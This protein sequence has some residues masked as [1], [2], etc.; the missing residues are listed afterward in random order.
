MG[1]IM[2]KKSTLVTAPPFP[3]EQA[4]RTLGANLRTARLR[5]KLSLGAVA[6]K[7]G[8]GRKI[9]ADAERGKLSTGI[10]VYVAL[11]WIYGLLDQFEEVAEPTR[12]REGQ[13]LALLRDPTRGGT[14][15]PRPGLD[16]DF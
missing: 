9:V 13:A 14:P 11:L 5:R 8:V 1:Y 15:G 4:I 7:I 10:N 6:D 3:V 2:T 12:D 16:N